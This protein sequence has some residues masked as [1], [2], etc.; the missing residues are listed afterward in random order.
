MEEL[1]SFKPLVTSIIK[2]AGELLLSYRL[3][4]LARVAKPEAGFVTQADT[5]VEEFLVTKLAN[6][7][8]SISFFTEENGN[9]RQTASD[10]CWVIDPL[11]GTTN[12]AYGLPHFCISIALTYRHVPQLG[13]VYQPLL[14]E[15]FIA[16]RGKGVVLNGVP[17]HV[18]AVSGLEDSFLLFCIPYR[19]NAQSKKIFSKVLELGQ[20]ASSLRLLGSAALDQC[21]VACGRLDGMFTEQLAWWDIAAG[22]LIVEEAGGLVSDYQGKA[23]NPQFNTY[24]AANP[25]IHTALVNTL[26]D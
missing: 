2:Q 13:F 14:N 8:P 3:K 25:A 12:F 1:A 7:D 21:Y 16:E 9:A 11:D 24:V 5:A 15:L 10:Y 17:I 20:Q 23:I 18:S 19:K 4:P 6:L 22:S 26:K